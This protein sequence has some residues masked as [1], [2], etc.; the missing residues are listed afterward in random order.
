MHVQRPEQGGLPGASLKQLRPLAASPSR[1][2]P[3]PSS[4]ACVPSPSPLFP[5]FSLAFPPFP[6]LCLQRAGA[7]QR[8]QAGAAVLIGELP[9]AELAVAF[10]AVLAVTEAEPGGSR[11]RLGCCQGRASPGLAGL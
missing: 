11:C 6:G 5:R 4:P 7:W 9:L 3:F 10:L 8:D 2:P 1:K